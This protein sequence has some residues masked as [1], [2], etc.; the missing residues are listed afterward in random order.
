MAAGCRMLKQD[1]KVGA[2]ILPHLFF[3]AFG[4]GFE[5]ALG[6]GFDALGGDAEVGEVIEHADGPSIAEGHVV[7]GGSAPIAVTFDEESA[8]GIIFEIFGDLLQG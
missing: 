4:D 6:D 1:D 3:G 7:F 5:V 2:A 8:V